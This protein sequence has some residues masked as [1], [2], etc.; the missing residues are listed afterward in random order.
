M[1]YP[2]QS[3]GIASLM[4]NAQAFRPMN[5]TAPTAPQPMAPQQ[6]PQMGMQQGFSAP[7]QPQQQSFPQQ[8]YMQLPAAIPSP[9]ITGSMQSPMQR[10]YGGGM[11]QRMQQGG[12]AYLP[13]MSYG[14]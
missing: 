3:G 5:Y 8:A 6:M 11:V 12:L 2:M 13:L 1:F 4:N 7:L 9:A 14:R 10:M